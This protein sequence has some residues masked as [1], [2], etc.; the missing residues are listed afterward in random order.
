[1]KCKAALTL[2][3][4]AAL[5][6]SG[7]A[8]QPEPDELE[9]RRLFD[10][11]LEV[12]LTAESSPATSELGRRSW[13]QAAKTYRR[14]LGLKPRSA[15]TH[16]N[17]GLVYRALGD[18]ERAGEHLEKAAK[19]AEADDRAFYQRKYAD[20]LRD[21]GDWGRASAIYERSALAQ[22]QDAETHRILL[23][24]YLDFEASGVDRLP[25]YLW[26]LVERGEVLRA[27]AAA[28]EALEKGWPEEG[29]TELLTV[30]A[31]SLGRRTVKP[32]VFLDSATGQSLR[33]LTGDKVIGPGVE[34][35]VEVF[36]TPGEYE[37]DF[38][39]W[40]GQGSPRE[41]PE[42]G[43]WP[44]SAFQAVMRR[45]GIW[46][47]RRNTEIAEV[48]Y[49]TAVTLSPE[50]LD[51]R[52]LRNLV[53][54]YAERGETK[55]MDAVISEYEDR[56]QNAEYRRT[57]GQIYG[58]LKRAVPEKPIRVPR[59]LP[60]G[61][62]KRPF[63]LRSELIDGGYEIRLLSPD[64][65][66]RL[67]LPSDLSP[68]DIISGSLQIMRPGGK[69]GRVPSLEKLRLTVGDLAIP[70]TE[71]RWSA[72]IRARVAGGAL[73]VAFVTRKG[74]HVAS[75]Q[76]PVAPAAGRPSTIPPVLAVAGRPLVVHGRFDGDS[77][78]TTV[79]V[80]GLEATVLGESPR[81]LILELPDAERQGQMV[82][83]VTERGSS[84]EVVVRALGLQ[85]EA[86]N[87]L[88]KRG[89]RTTLMVRV[90]GLEGLDGAFHIE[91]R[92]LTPTIGKLAAGAAPRITVRPAEVKAGVF[93]WTTEVHALRDGRVRFKASVVR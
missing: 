70:L 22:P 87:P 45:V 66:A 47:E 77:S 55:K 88:L 36:S 91:L 14:V 7:A 93:A 29:R 59:E 33:G 85:I 16:Y 56:V 49:K 9:A 63:N 80:G 32:S 12:Q 42:R 24:R 31:A 28:L 81:Q 54:L 15:S 61:E 73:R 78:T 57:V 90:T 5:V 34:E 23:D 30:V 40:S 51:A 89:Q 58:Y 27:E 60:E 44:R 4:T 39:W 86:R 71:A 26:R 38:R 52:A 82:L 3:A 37:S 20:H 69:S 1:M 83:E 72:T 25:V 2:L 75:I 48:C 10:L 35:L 6:A 17:L 43:V 62:A 67:T 74:K 8:G 21:S 76:V 65:S 64:G 19:F 84:V 18:V 68:G 50:D 79:T 46:Y 11:A 53:Q 41:D 92:N 13:R